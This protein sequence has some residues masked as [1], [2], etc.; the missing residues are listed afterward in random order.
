M[1]IALVGCGKKKLE[2]PSPACE[3]YQSHRYE[4]PFAHMRLA[5][6]TKKMALDL[7]AA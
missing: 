2:C 3:L 5:T 1:R 4:L 6:R 7:E